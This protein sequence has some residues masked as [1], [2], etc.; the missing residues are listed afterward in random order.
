MKHVN[1]VEEAVNAATVP[2]GSR[3]YSSGN[4]AT[5][6]VLLKQLATDG[7]IRDVELFGVL[8]LGDTETLFPRDL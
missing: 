8:F 5:P 1:R 2:S 6:Q 7:S 4:A 3:I